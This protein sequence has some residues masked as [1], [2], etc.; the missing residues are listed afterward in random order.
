MLISSIEKKQA[1]APSESTI[2]L[3]VL[4]RIQKVDPEFP[5]QYIIC[6]M[7]ISEN[8]GCSI[9]NL[10]DRCGMALS[11][12][13]RIVGA[14]SDYRQRGEPYRFIET[15]TSQIER[16]KKELYLTKRGDKFLKDMLK[17]LK[18]AS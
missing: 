10:A 17:P 16:R 7:E 15:R 13:S 4:R 18:K 8:Q 1:I 12:V 5:I 9:T 3:D 14:L 2:L 6:L 11:T